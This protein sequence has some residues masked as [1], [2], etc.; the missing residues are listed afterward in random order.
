[1]KGIEMKI[2]Y[3]DPPYPGCA[4]RY[5][6]EASYAGEV[7]HE[8]LIANLRLYDGFILHTSST[9]LSSILGM[10]ANDPI[11]VMAWVKPFAAF[12]RNV[13][14]AYAWEP[15]I[16]KAARKPVVSKRLI[17]RD[18]C[19]CSITLKKGLCGAKPLDVCKWLFEAVGAR[20]EDDLCDL[21]P[22]T[23]A[24]SKAWDE[25]RKLFTLPLLE[26]AGRVK[27]LTDYES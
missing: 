12:K 27:P 24:V 26:E 21:Y 2:A 15:V 17:M 7:D 6:G 22:G 10:M 20:P 8:E 9:A 16:V 13:S 5:K 1:M 19:S 23:G 11:R 3:A 18:W 4:H 25:W 14:V